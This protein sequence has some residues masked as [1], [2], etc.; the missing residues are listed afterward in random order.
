M[1]ALIGITAAAGLGQGG[2][3]LYDGFVAALI[4][5]GAVVNWL[6]TRWR[7]DG[8][9]L[10]IE[11]GLLR[12]DSRQLPVARIQAV[13]VVRP[14]LARALGL[15]ELRVRLAGSSHADGRLAYLPEQAALQ[16]RAR[17]LAAHH[18]LDPATPE[19]A[20]AILAQVPTWPPGRLGG[21]VQ[22]QPGGRAAG[23][24]GGRA[25]RVPRGCWPPPG[26]C[27][28]IW[29]L[30]LAPVLW[31]RISLEY[32]F[33]VAAGAGWHPDPP[34]PAVHRGGNHPA[35]AGAGGPDDRAAAVA[36]AGL[37]PA[38]DRRGRVGRAGT[39]PRRPAGLRKALLPVGHRD[40]AWQ[41]MRLVIGAE[42][43]PLSRHRRG[44][45]G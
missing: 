26:A 23:C 22:H 18:G 25:H 19:P 36:A 2:S 6:V 8:A 16:L 3:H 33:T 5:A 14:F 20:E 35:A 44:G 4:A 29:V 32:G 12:R 40:T 30:G 27:W 34:R 24:R 41:L 42:P 28:S 45:P 7:L 21:A 9:T 38:G 37:V 1:L 39:T 31:R 15:A 43:P 17:L 11:T 13:D 10:C